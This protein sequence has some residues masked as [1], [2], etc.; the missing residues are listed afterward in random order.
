M[1][2]RIDMPD[3]MK[4]KILS[5]AKDIG[6]RIRRQ[7]TGW[8]K[9]FVKDKSEKIHNELLELNNKKTNSPTKK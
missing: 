2:E 3:F 8:E 4:I 7:A 9:V 5:S 6:K 1:K